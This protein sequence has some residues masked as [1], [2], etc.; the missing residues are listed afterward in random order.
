M[1]EWSVPMLSRLRYSISFL[2]V[3]FVTEF[4]LSQSNAVKIESYDITATLPSVNDTLLSVKAFV[5]AT[6]LDDSH[7]LTFLFNSQILNPKITIDKDGAEYTVKSEF[8][9]KDSLQVHFPPAALIPGPF[10]MTLLYKFPIE[11]VK[12]NLTLIDRGHRWY[13][14]IADQISKIKMTAIIPRNC[15]ALSAGN[16]IENPPEFDISKTGIKIVI[17]QCNSP[18]FK[19]PLVIFN[20]NK[21][22]IFNYGWQSK[23]VSIVTSIS[24]TAL[25]SGVFNETQ[26]MLE[27]CAANFGEYS[28]NALTI[29]E[30]PEF[31][32]INIGSGLIQVGSTYFDAFKTGYYDGLHLAIA[33]QWFG[34]SV[35][36]KYGE[37]GFWFMALSLPHYVRIMHLRETKGEEAY[38]DELM[39]P[40][41][42][43]KEFAGSDNDVPILNVDMP[44]TKE[45]GIVL[46]T[47]GPYVISLLHKKLGDENWKAFLKE[48]YTDYKG[49]ILSYPEFCAQLSKQD[50]DGELM[51]F[52][53][54]AMTGKGLPD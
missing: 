47:K 34:A 24:D 6:K 50:G 3:F 48:L 2:L 11:P 27:F 30:V 1:G 4:S 54:N 26:S 22:K 12:E 52:F 38:N 29:C 31:E 14:L 42:K 19:I 28:Y 40:I 10:S 32:G 15:G 8:T 16:L 37:P 43:Y 17:W 20:L 35:F 46:Y 7:I 23:A 9:G 51:K 5:S 25:I 39:K 18:V 44:N 13:P 36:A 41:E 21:Y 45:K 53:N 49:K 33:E